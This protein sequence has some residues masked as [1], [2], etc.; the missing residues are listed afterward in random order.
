MNMTKK[1]AWF[2]FDELRRIVSIYTYIISR[3]NGFVKPFFACQL[4]L[5]VNLNNII[6]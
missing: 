6:R 1:T 2:L 3:K 5:R 4:L